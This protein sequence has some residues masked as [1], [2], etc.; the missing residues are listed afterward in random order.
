MARRGNEEYDYSAIRES[1]NR[2]YS[3]DLLVT[4]SVWSPNPLLASNSPPAL[5][6]LSQKLI[7]QKL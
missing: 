1:A 4:S 2:T 5:F 3:P 7:S 6:N